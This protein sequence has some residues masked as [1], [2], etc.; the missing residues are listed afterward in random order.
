MYIDPNLKKSIILEEDMSLYK[1]HVLNI[2]IDLDKFLKSKGIK[3]SLDGGTLLGAIRHNGFIPWDDDIDIA[4]N[5]KEFL[6]MLDVIDEFKSEKYDVYVPLDDSPIAIGRMVKI[7]DK[8]VCIKEYGDRCYAGAF[9]DIFSMMDVGNDLKKENTS[10]KYRLLTTLLMHKNKRC[11]KGIYKTKSGMITKGLSYCVS[12][13]WLKKKIKSYYEMDSKCKWCFSSFGNNKYYRK[14][15]FEEFTEHVFEGYVF[16]II[17]E[18]DEFLTTLYGDYMKLP[19]EDERNPHHLEYLC[20]DE[21]YRE[22]NLK[23]GKGDV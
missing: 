12:K 19:P 17:K 8:S 21:C 15:M 2:L 4:M 9:V 3:Y 20:F 16:P 23:E 14:E 7:Y 11:E 5:K 1:S 10:N 13:S 18:Y 22:K 6:K